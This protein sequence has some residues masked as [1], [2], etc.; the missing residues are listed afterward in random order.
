MTRPDLEA[1]A[2]WVAPGARVLDLGCGDGSL[3]KHLW[4]NHQAHGYGVEIDDA[5]VLASM[6]ND[7]NVL[8][9]DLESGLALFHDASFDYV[10]LSET[11]QTIHRIEQLT[12]EMLR[13]GREVIVSFPNFGH[14]RDRLQV[15][16]GRMPV[17]EE[18]P[19]QWY[20]TPNVHLCTLADFED[21][22][23]R[24]GARILERA[25]LH[26]GRAVRVLPNLFG[27]IAV[28]RVTA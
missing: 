23:A 18:L 17:S 1:I 13:V 27:S 25:V 11:L 16:L 2:R 15:L 12:R 14:W 10:I 7:V 3:L 26:R 21:L 22:C 9:L 4:D 6:R 20:D 8:Q 5:E 28:Y 24:L 19:H